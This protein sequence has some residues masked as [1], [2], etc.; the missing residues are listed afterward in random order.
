MSRQSV[1]PLWQEPNPAIERTASGGPRPS[2]AAAHVER[3]APPHLAHWHH[4]HFFL[5][6]L[7]NR[8][9]QEK[10]MRLLHTMIAA[11]LAM[12]GGSPAIALADPPVDVMQIVRDADVKWTTGQFG[13]GLQT[14]VLAGNPSQPGMYV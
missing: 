3:W 1:P 9:E 4:E 8:T 14:A 13:T 10:T 11:A 6:S 5:G 2:T 7:T 12:A